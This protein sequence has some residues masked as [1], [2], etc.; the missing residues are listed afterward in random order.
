[1]K[2]KYW[3]VYG[4]DI[5]GTGNEEQEARELKAKKQKA[6]ALKMPKKI[7]M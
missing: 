3:Y 7:G 6:K 4:L 1:M 5:I 2:S